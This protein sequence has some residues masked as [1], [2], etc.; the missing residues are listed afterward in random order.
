[1]QKLGDMEIPDEIKGIVITK[2]SQYVKDIMKIISE[3]RGLIFPKDIEEGVKVDRKKL[4]VNRCGEYIGWI[5]AVLNDIIFKMII[6]M[7]KNRTR[8]NPNV[9]TW[10]DISNILSNADY[11]AITSLCIQEVERLLDLMA[12]L[13]Q[14]NKSKKKEKNEEGNEEYRISNQDLYNDAVAKLEKIAPNNIKTD[15]FGLKFYD[16]QMKVHNQLKKIIKNVFKDDDTKSS[17]L[18]SLNKDDEEDEVEEEGDDDSGDEDI[19][20]EMNSKDEEEGEGEESSSD[21]NKSSEAKIRTYSSAV[22]YLNVL[23]E[24]L[25]DRFTR[26]AYTISYSSKRKTMDEE[27]VYNAMKIILVGEL[28]DQIYQNTFDTVEAIKKYR[29][30]RKAQKLMAKESTPEKT[31]DETPKVGKG[32]GAKKVEKTVEAPKSEEAE[33]SKAG[34]GD[35]TTK[36]KKKEKAK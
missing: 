6:K 36:K 2:K 17:I 28:G 1:M 30:E 20:E 29:N 5:F 27:D 33:S 4:A 31:T 14:L 10:R 7:V 22:L 24:R 35:K 21:K 23:A 18:S 34:G 19:E 3:E 11:T 32:K 15:R 12:Y 13:E 25:T 8:E 9:I 16:P 26:A